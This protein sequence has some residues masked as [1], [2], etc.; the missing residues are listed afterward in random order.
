MD[1]DQREPKYEGPEEFDISRPESDARP[2]HW[3]GRGAKILVAVGAL[4][5]LLSMFG[6]PLL[7][8]FRR[9]AEGAASSIERTPAVVTNVIDGITIA[10]EV[11]GRP[12]SVRYLGVRPPEFGTELYDLTA[13]VNQSWVQGTEV[14]LERDVTDTDLEG[15]LLRYVWLEDAMINAALLAYG[16]ARHAP[17]PPDTRYSA[18]FDRIEAEARLR[19]LGM[20]Q[21]EVGDATGPSARVGPRAA[22]ATRLPGSR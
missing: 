1:P 16:L 17:R 2:G 4:L 13:A 21:A 12:A 15:R 11:D 3:I 20:W 8:L 18:N 22:A 10:V 9:P 7:D 19:G 5:I 14:L 6:R